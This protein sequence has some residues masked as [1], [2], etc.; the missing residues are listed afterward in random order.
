M[1]ERLSQHV[2]RNYTQF[3]AGVAEVSALEAHLINAHV[4]AKVSPAKMP[5]LAGLD[6]RN[7]T[8]KCALRCASASSVSVLPRWGQ[9]ARANLGLVRKNV[10]V[11]TWVAARSRRKQARWLPPVCCRLHFW[12]LAVSEVLLYRHC[13]DSNLTLL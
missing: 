13:L 4:Y 1:S 3:V 9:E 5:T 2:L 8:S 7:P 11:G 10:A 6:P 12:D